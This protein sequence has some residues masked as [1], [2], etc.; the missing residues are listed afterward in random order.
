[1]AGRSVIGFVA[2]KFGIPDTTFSVWTFFVG[3]PGWRCFV[4][5]N[6][7][8]YPF[9][10]CRPAASPLPIMKTLLT[11]VFTAVGLVVLLHS[12]LTPWRIVGKEDALPAGAPH[13]V[14]RRYAVPVAP[15][16]SHSGDW[17]RD[18]NYRSALER[19][20]VVG[21]PEAAAPRDVD[22]P[23]HPRAADFR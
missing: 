2:R 5:R 20:T 8:R 18:P 4:G 17:M 3:L 1:M 13:A 12:D 19:T 16:Q 10:S 9:S 6:L 22:K 21:R 11:V 15:T 7:F 23:A 14:E